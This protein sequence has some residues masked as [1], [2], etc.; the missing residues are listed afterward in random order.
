MKTALLKMSFWAKNNTRIAQ[1]ILVLFSLC[2]ATLFFVIGS[3]MQG[4]F[5]ISD[6]TPY[7]LVLLALLISFLYNKVA[8]KFLIKKALIGLMY[9]NASMLSCYFGYEQALLAS[10]ENTWVLQSASLYPT[11]S[12][13]PTHWTEELPNHRKSVRKLI[14]QYKSTLKNYIEKHFKGTKKIWLKILLTLLAWVLYGALL[15]GVAA[16]ACSYSC[17]GK[18]FEAVLIGFGGLVLLTLAFAVV[19]VKIWRKKPKDKKSKKVE[20]EEVQ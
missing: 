19:V 6:F 14:R 17:A 12:P 8:K 2:N 11:A 18:E 3:L 4:S 13:N 5:K 9:L 10:R 20:T 15:I 1:T 16:I 7:F